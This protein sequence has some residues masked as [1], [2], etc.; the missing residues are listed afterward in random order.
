M[1]GCPCNPGTGWIRASARPALFHRSRGRGSRRRRGWRG[2]SCQIRQHGPG[3]CPGGRRPPGRAA[4]TRR[5][6][7][8]R[9]RTKG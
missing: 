3:R 5:C 4:R 9:P 7:R 6:G 1:R 8:H 2:H